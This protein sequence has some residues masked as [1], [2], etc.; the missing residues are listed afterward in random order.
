M[1]LIRKQSVALVFAACFS[2]SV[3][4]AD[5]KTGGNAAS[6]FERAVAAQ[7]KKDLESAESH[8]RAL[9]KQFPKSPLAPN[10]LVS[11]VRVLG[12]NGKAAE[13][14]QFI[15]KGKQDYAQVPGLV[16]QLDALGV[17]LGQ[18]M[19]KKKNKA[20]AM[21]KAKE[22]YQARLKEMEQRL[23]AAK[24]A[25][26][27]QE[28]KGITNSIARLKK[29]WQQY[30]QKAKNDKKPKNRNR[31]NNQQINVEEMRRQQE[32][33]I[34]KA[35]ELEDEG[36]TE[37]AYALR[38]KADS[39]AIQI[40]ESRRRPKNKKK[41][42]GKNKNKNREQVRMAQRRLAE[43]RGQIQKV[44]KAIAEAKA[45]GQ[46]EQAKEYA[47]VV[48][49]LRKEAGKIQKQ[50]QGASRNNDKNARREAKKVRRA[51]KKAQKELEKAKASGND[52][53]AEELQKRVD[54][55]KKRFKNLENSSK[56]QENANYK[57]QL[58]RLARNLKR[59]GLSE[60]EIAQRLDF[61]KNEQM[62]M[63][64][65]NSEL[66][67][68][69][70]KLREEGKPENEIKATVTKERQSFQRS[71]AERRRE[72]NQEVSKARRQRQDAQY[73]AELEERMAAR[74]QELSA[75]NADEATVA[76]AMASVKA[77]FQKEIKL[78][79]AE[80]NKK[81]QEN[82]RRF[83]RESNEERLKEMAE[84]LR[85]RGLS[86]DEIKKRVEKMRKKYARP[87]N[88]NTLESKSA[89]KKKKKKGK[90]NKGNDRAAQR[91]KELEREV[92]RLR[93]LL[94]E[95]K[96]DQAKAPASRPAQP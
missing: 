42:K 60:E 88:S 82:M 58:S 78:R 32:E 52:A 55:L 61:A 49:N 90:K 92:K 79:N 34:A 22:K 93:K 67:T 83:R 84:R 68:L 64:K 74:K 91:I 87:S 73:K 56:R 45:S 57:R 47:A 25:G 76:K 7:N 62:L 16:D 21:A 29:Q 85:K 70:E 12:Q 65:H 71:V 54:Q 39:I 37:E 59:Q 36:K 17:H 48:A 27:E 77:E 4:V 63:S 3:A 96:N 15:E 11:L 14:M 8:Y 9:L 26:N 24:E 51:L 23:Q 20:K 28:A 46:E 41:G 95:K 1:R 10:A 13:G 31:G 38:Q 75:Q 19:G 6:L 2:L 89:G 80:E 81:R 72:F 44:N 30:G 43:L 94:A 35:H 66:E 5:D 40:E 69:T 50:I 18:R 53:A 86:E 33:L